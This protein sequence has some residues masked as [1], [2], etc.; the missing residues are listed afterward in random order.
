VEADAF[1]RQPYR[2]VLAEGGEVVRIEIPGVGSDFAAQSIFRTDL[3]ATLLE[4]IVGLQY[5]LIVVN[6]TA[7]RVRVADL[8]PLATGQCRAIP[9]KRLRG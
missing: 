5:G 2:R 8:P 7:D 9:K 4:W 3:T 1:S 6:R